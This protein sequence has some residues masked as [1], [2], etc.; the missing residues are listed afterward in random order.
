MSDPRCFIL[1]TM[2]SMARRS[3]YRLG[4]YRLAILAAQSERA[5]LI[6]C[7]HYRFTSG[8]ADSGHGWTPSGVPRHLSTLANLWRWPP[9]PPQSSLYYITLCRRRERSAS[10]WL[11]LVSLRVPVYMVR[12]LLYCANSSCSLSAVFGGHFGSVSAGDNP[13]NQDPILILLLHKALK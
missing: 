8:W 3:V 12:Y 10:N 11:S 7:F 9:S 1:Q 4:G 13:T 2:V 5:A 6:F